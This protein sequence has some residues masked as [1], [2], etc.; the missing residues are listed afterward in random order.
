MKPKEQKLVKIEE[1]FID[2]ISGSA[3]VKI[4]DK[5]MQS[6]MMLKLKCTQNPVFSD[7]IKGSS[8]IVILSPKEAI[9][10]L[11]FRSLGYYKIT[12]RG[13]TTKSN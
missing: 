5:L 10:I 6:T 13:T 8:D 2:E 9:G 3:I 1:P 4:L 7:I 12:A 11:D